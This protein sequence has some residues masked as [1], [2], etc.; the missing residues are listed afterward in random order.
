[1]PTLGPIE[2]ATIGGE[3]GP[4]MT[5]RQVLLYGFTSDSWSQGPP[6]PVPLNHANAVAHAGY[7]QVGSKFYVLG[8]RQDGATETRDTVFVLDLLDVAAGWT[9]VAGRM[10]TPRGGLAAAA[11]GTKTRILSEFKFANPADLRL[12]TFLTC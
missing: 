3:S 9:T 6:L 5:T 1:M 4:N 8:G 12:N 7:A 10:P 2:L 11:V